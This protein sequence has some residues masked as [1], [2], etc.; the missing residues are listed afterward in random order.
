VS[1]IYLSPRTVRCLSLPSARVL[2]FALRRLAGLPVGLLAC[3]R[4]GEPDGLA[5]DVVRSLERYQRVQVGRLDTA[6][7]RDLLED[8]LDQ[9]FTSR[10]MA[11]I[12]RVAGGNPFFALELAEAEA[13]EGG[14]EPTLK[15]P[16][17][18]RR[19]VSDRISTLSDRAR[20][21][22]LVERDAVP[23]E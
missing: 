4:R 6:T 1:P 22:L 11:R 5:D 7:L 13:G 21:A 17:R 18:L 14:D 20:N 3:V 15:L 2:A 19:I 8:R 10:A 23:A 16:D 9:R 12:D